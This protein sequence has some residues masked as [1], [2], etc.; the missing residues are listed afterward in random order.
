MNYGP[1]KWKQLIP[2]I[3]SY[4][5]MSHIQA[6]VICSRKAGLQLSVRSGGHD[7]EG[8]SYASNVPFIIVDLLNFLSINVDIED[9]SAW[10]QVGS[11]L[12]DVYY[13][14]AEI[15]VCLCIFLFI[16]YGG[17]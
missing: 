7:Y 4:T 16:F 2:A 12:G 1:L 17:E 3:G 14:V 15:F 9:N 10:I 6:T 5:N 11:I 13:R 8:L